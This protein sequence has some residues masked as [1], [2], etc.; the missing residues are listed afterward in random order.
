[1]TK[2]IAKLIFCDNVKIEHNGDAISS[3]ISNVLSMLQPVNIPSNYSF[4][5]A[6]IFNG[7]DPSKHNEMQFTLKNPN[8]DTILD[9]G[10]VPF[11]TVPDG[12]QN[13][14]PTIQLNLDLRNIVLDSEGEY[15]AELFLNSES[16]ETDTILVKKV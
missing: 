16:V 4:C 6:C 10:K 2:S 15:V 7:V 8:G 12:P 14:A 3:S 11:P 13:A 5:V 9:T 1:M